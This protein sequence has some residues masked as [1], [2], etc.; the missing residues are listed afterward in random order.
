MT[1][2]DM[3]LLDNVYSA[4]SMYRGTLLA[5]CLMLRDVRWH[6][7]RLQLLVAQE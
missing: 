4:A 2:L 1:Q 7:W 3:C 5:Q 6:A